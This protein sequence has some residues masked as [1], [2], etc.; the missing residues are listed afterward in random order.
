MEADQ[1]RLSILTL[2]DEVRKKRRDE[3]T[4]RFRSRDEKRYYSSSAFLAETTGVDADGK[5]GDEGDYILEDADGID[6]N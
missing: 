5:D 6:S 4:K 1:A 2:S 3:R